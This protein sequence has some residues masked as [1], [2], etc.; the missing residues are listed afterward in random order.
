MYFFLSQ[1][2]IFLLSPFLLIIISSSCNTTPFLFIFS[3]QIFFN[4]FFFH[5]LLLYSYPHS[6]LYFPLLK[7]EVPLFPG[8][9]HFYSHCATYDVFSIV[10]GLWA[11]RS[12]VR[13][14]AEERNFSPI[15]RLVLGTQL[16][17]YSKDNGSSPVG[18]KTAMA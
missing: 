17:P 1:R 13:F 11:V 8:Y 16:I 14:L 2:R 6:P 9:S 10:T 12:E 15:S 7:L 4:Y 3:R 18:D 5:C